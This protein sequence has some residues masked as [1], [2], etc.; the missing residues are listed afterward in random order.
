M[1]SP[2]DMGL[3]SVNTSWIQTRPRST[4]CYNE[5]VSC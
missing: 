3:L 1:S 2:T 5:T 4:N